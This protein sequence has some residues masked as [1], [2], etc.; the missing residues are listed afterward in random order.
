MSYSTM[1][2]SGNPLSPEGFTV[3]DFNQVQP[4][5][6][7]PGSQICDTG[8]EKAGQWQQ[9]QRQ[10]RRCDHGWLGPPL[11]GKQGRGGPYDQSLGHAVGRVWSRCQLHLAWSDRHPYFLGRPPDSIGCRK[12]KVEQWV[13][14]CTTMRLPR[15][16]PR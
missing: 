16:L 11:F 3:E 6:L 1:P 15:T 2:A 12:Q 5:L 8:Y 9:H 14:P 4:R 13:A 10:H 7:F